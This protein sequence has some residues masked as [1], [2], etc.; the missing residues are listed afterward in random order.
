MDREEIERLIEEAGNSARRKQRMP[1]ARTMRTILNTLFL[2]GAA[3][4][5]VWYF[6]QP[7]DSHTGQFIIAGAMGLKV[8]E[9]FIRFMF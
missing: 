6:V 1:S 8:I 7:Q 3:V 9:F 4:G 2:I 5:L